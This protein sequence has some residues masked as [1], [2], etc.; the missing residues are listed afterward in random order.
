M[1]K[2]QVYLVVDKKTNEKEIMLVRDWGII[3]MFTRKSSALEFKKEK[4]NSKDLKVVKFK[5][6]ELNN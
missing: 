6:T 5:L 2:E 4:I 3:P 1:N